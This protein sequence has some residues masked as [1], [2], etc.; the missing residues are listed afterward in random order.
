MNELSVY[1]QITTILYMVTTSELKQLEAL[2]SKNDKELKVITSQKPD[3]FSIEWL[4]KAEA[5]RDGTVDTDNLAEIDLRN[6]RLELLFKSINTELEEFSEPKEASR[7]GKITKE[8][9]E[10]DDT[11]NET[12]I[13]FPTT[14]LKAHE[15]T[16][17]LEIDIMGSSLL[18]NRNINQLNDTNSLEHN[19]YDVTRS[20]TKSNNSMINDSLKSGGS[21]NSILLCGKTFE[22]RRPK[23]NHR[24]T[25]NKPSLFENEVP[26]NNL[27][28]KP[29]K[30]FRSV[31]LCDL[32]FPNLNFKK[33][34]R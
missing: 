7:P 6:K 14:F 24:C 33:P 22:E 18:I 5:N 19:N 12:C 26:F 29:L 15:L 9:S 31:S 21:V 1:S 28:T 25:R 27:N 30:R 8:G 16:N 13:N 23:T 4:L 32:V 17:E 11:R 20:H 3:L 10:N 34:K 2:Y